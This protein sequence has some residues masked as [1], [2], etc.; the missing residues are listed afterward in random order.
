MKHIIL[1]VITLTFSS[2]F[3]TD[4]WN[5]GPNEKEAKGNWQYLVT[6]M[7]A[8]EELKAGTPCNWL[9]VN[10][11]DLHVALYKYAER[12][13]KAKIKAE[14]VAEAEEVLQDSLLSIYDTR[15]T[16]F[17]DEANV[18]NRKGKVAW[19]YQ[20]KYK[21]KHTELYSM[22]KKI[23]ELNGKEAYDANLFYYFS[24]ASRQK[25]SGN[26]TETQ[27]LDLYTQLDDDF[28]QR[29]TASPK[30]AESINNYR[31]KID[32]ELNKY[33]VVDCDF[34]QNNYGPQFEKEPSLAL[35]KKIQGLLLKNKCISNDLFVTTTNF[36]IE[37]E[38]PTYA[39]LKTLANIYLQQEKNEEAY[40]TYEKAI[41]VCEDP[42]KKADTYMTLAKLDMKNNKK[43][44]SKTNILKAIALDNSLET[45]GHN[46]IGSL[47]MSSANEC[48][49]GDPLQDRLVYIAAYNE[50][51]KAHNTSKMNTAKQQFPSMEDIFVHNKQL[52]E[53]MNTGCWIHESV[54][55]Q[56]R[57]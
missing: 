32:K 22:Y 20:Y 37:K 23:Y 51:K 6:L 28:A 48:S 10:T 7:D 39:N 15:I 24:A 31:E 13:Y 3:A 34:V 53:T 26:L 41:E 1:L 44:S 29:A 42:T 46:L 14:K 33:I 25:K 16:L 17:G 5:W 12:V 2:S 55:L 56:K 57:D 54:A 19:I 30:D 18:L 40:A 36:I 11:P 9:L 47:Y 4:T 52:G 35:S 43:V 8:D 38:G 21:S 50:F 27:L 49:T 45:E